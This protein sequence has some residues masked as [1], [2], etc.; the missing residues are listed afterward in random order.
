MYNIKYKNLKERG[1]VMT[2]KE[3]A[4]QITLKAIES[5]LI[6]KKRVDTTVS[7]SNSKNA[8]EIANFFT[9]I[10]NTI[11]KVDDAISVAVQ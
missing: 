5:G 4:M 11:H 1:K 2:D 6:Y 10:Y 7:D 3:I 9:T 8:D